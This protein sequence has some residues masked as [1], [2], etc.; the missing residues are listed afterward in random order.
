MTASDF[1]ERRPSRSFHSAHFHLR[2]GVLPAGAPAQAS[3]V[4][5]LKVAAT[6]TARNLLR[7]RINAVLDE[8]LRDATGFFLTVTAKTGASALP[9]S[10]LKHELGSLRKGAFSG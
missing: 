5:S 1:K 2:L 7:R 10:S 9:F 4:V 3:A 6:T 8:H